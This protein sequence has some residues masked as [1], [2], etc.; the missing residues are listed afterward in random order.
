LYDATNQLTTDGS[1]SHAY[2]NNGNRTDPGYSAGAGNQL[3][4]D[5]TWN[6]HYDNEGNRMNKVSIA[7]GDAWT[8]TYD[9]D[10]HLTTAIHKDSSGNLLETVDYRYDVFGNLLE[11][12]TLIPGFATSVSRHAY[13]SNGQLLADHDGSCNLVTRYL[14]GDAVDQVLARE[15]A[16]GS[17]AWYLGDREGSVRDLVNNSGAVI[18]QIAYDAFGKKTSE[19]TPSSGD[20]FGYA[21][22]QYDI[23]AGAYIFNARYYD[24]TTGSWTT[25]DPTG[26]GGGDPN[27]YRY[28]ANQPTDMTDPSGLD[29]VA[30][31]GTD[32]GDN[33]T[34]GERHIIGKIDSR[35]GYLNTVSLSEA[36]GEYDV[37]L[38]EL[39]QAARMVQSGSLS[40]TQQD[41][42]MFYQIQKTHVGLYGSDYPTRDKIVGIVDAILQV[43]FDITA[44]ANGARAG[45]TAAWIRRGIGLDIVSNENGAPYHRGQVAGNTA[46]LIA[47]A[48]HLAAMGPARPAPRASQKSVEARVQAL[49]GSL[50]P[51]PKTSAVTNW[52]GE[53]VRIPEGHVMSPSDPAMSAP[54]IYE[55]GPFTTAERADMLSGESGGTRLSPHH[56]HQLPTTWGGVIDELPGPGHP[57]GNTHTKGTPSRHPSASIFNSMEGGKTLRQSEISSHWNGKGLRL[58]EVE[59]DVWV[60]PGPQ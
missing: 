57:T 27:L 15:S 5:G 35:G 60:D 24:P 29:S 33:P 10:N 1:I 20:R 23:G 21:G 37:P 56:R 19:S 9:N 6:Y 34:L 49:D 58:I 38:A 47:Q 8:Y 7:N 52:R 42:V 59:P 50:T 53:P 25:Q 51:R 45:D 43:P 46:M 32:V 4:T 40:Y 41:Q 11:E 16:S 54:P 17:V 22:A 30:V 44:M 18:D 26:F 12:D 36:F 14:N 13:D 28:V 48:P 3:L 39:Q 31:V 55:A 2:D